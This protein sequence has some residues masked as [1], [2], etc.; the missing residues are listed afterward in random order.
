ML[1]SFAHDTLDSLWSNASI[2]IPLATILYISTVI[3]YRLF[4]SPLSRVPGPRLAAITKFYLLYHDFM[5][6]KTRKVTQLHQQYGPVVRIAPNEISYTS[7]D[8]IKQ[9]YTGTGRE[10]GFPK[11]KLYSLLSH[12]GELNMVSSITSTDHTWRRKANAAG[13]TQTYILK[14]EATDGHI[15][16]NVGKFSDFITRE[17]L[18][19]GQTP[20]RSVDLARISAY[21]ALDV[22]TVHIFGQTLGTHCLY[23]PSQHKDVIQHRQIIADMQDVRNERG[24]NIYLVTDLKLPLVLF[25]TVEGLYN[26][27]LRVLSGEPEPESFFGFEST[28][29]Y[30]LGAYNEAK[31]LLSTGLAPATELQSQKLIQYVSNNGNKS[32][33]EKGERYN[34]SVND[35]WATSEIV[36]IIRWTLEN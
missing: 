11:A 4:L 8:A 28:K 5:Q 7:A 2:V 16:M 3:I 13:W 18:I 36:V 27:C 9:I 20:G 17:G 6:R 21:Y 24:A 30:V 1:S 26:S 22:V 12:F 23:S 33:L 29:V 35:N 34:D 32:D 10:G 25:E 14:K 31:K 19:D 15:W